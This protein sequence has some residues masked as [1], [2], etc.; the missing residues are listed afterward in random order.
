MC[1]AYHHTPPVSVVVVSRPPSIQRLSRSNVRRC[2]QLS[3]CVYLCVR[4][5]VLSAPPPMFGH[6]ISYA[7]R[8]R[9]R[10]WGDGGGRIRAKL[11]LSVSFF[12]FTITLLIRGGPVFSFL[13][14]SLFEK[15][16]KKRT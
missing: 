3:Q 14:L 5:C 13:A 9:E 11:A 16:C 7:R 1:G 2:V 15:M 8:V 4:E 10:R 6:A 12:S